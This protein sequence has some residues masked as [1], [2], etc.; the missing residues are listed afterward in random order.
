MGK[1]SLV[2]I[3]SLFSITV[4]AQPTDKEIK[5]KLENY[6][7]TALKTE[8]FSGAVLVAKNNKVLI[9]KGYGMANYEYDIPNSPTTKFR[10]A[11]LTKAFTA[12]MTLQLVEAGE[13]RLAGTIRD[14]LPDYPGPNGDSIT[15][16]QLLSHTS[17][18]PHYGDDYLEKYSKIYVAPAEYMKTF[19]EKP[20][21]FRPGTKY[22]YSSPGYFLLGVILE[23]VAGQSYR[24][25]LREKITAPLGM[26]NTL[27]EEN[28]AI[29]KIKAA[30]Y[31]YLFDHHREYK[32]PGL[33]NAAYE[34]MS[35]AGGAGQLL[36][37]V[38]DLYKWNLALS[39]DKL[40]SKPYRDLLFKPNMANY[41]YG[42]NIIKQG[43]KGSA[44][45]QTVAEHG[46][47]GLGF[48]SHL[49]KNLDNG[50]FIVV[51]SNRSNAAVKNMIDDIKAILHGEKYSLPKIAVLPDEK[52]NVTFRLKGHS[53]ANKVF[54]SGEFNNWVPWQTF[55]IK[56]G[57]E[58]VCR[59]HLAKGTYKYMFVV[60]GNW[61]PDPDNP[62]QDKSS[63]TSSVV[64][65]E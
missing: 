64:K 9:S 12:V 30:G 47:H 15:I 65:V 56:N 14:Y 21:L 59:V 36:S 29:I 22:S 2:F 8:N 18:L 49:S 38:E 61:I 3:L 45:K 26:P 6:F 33:A 40:L 58:W 24:D 32:Y 51:L 19:A 25:L 55:L 10:I 44:G 11:S 63:F 31:D 53:S 60:D 50:E 34:E 42:W 43:M 52:G 27:V 37:T 7:E 5:V 20:L 13:L 62:L 17:G 39:S 57:E 35:K 46:G 4:S 48:L 23:K 41:A 28:N 1:T 54:V 16:H